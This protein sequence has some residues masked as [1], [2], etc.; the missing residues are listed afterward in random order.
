MLLPKPEI[1]DLT[2]VQSEPETYYSDGRVVHILPAPA[3]EKRPEAE[4]TDSQFV[5]KKKT[6]TSY[7]M[8]QIRALERIFLDTPYPDTE[9]IET[10]SVELDISEQK[11]RVS[12]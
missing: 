7:S 8:K 2:K 10:I 12:N 1:A 11:L 6:R 5:I 9:K 3:S 4:S